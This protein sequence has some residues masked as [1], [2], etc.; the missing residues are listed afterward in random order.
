VIHVTGDFGVTPLSDN[1]IIIRQSGYQSK[2][3][4][5]QFASTVFI[6]D[7]LAVFFNSEFSIR[8]KGAMPKVG[9]C[10]QAV[11]GVLHSG[12]NSLRTMMRNGAY[13]LGLSY[14]EP[15]T[16][17]SSSRRRSKLLSLLESSSLV[18]TDF[19]KRGKYR[20]GATTEEERYRTTMEFFNSIIN[21]DYTLCVRGGGNFS[22]RIYETMALGR[23]PLFV[24]TDSIL[25]FDD[26]ID[27]KQHLVWVE[28]ADLKRVGEILA[29]FHQSIH[30]DDFKQLQ[31]NNRNMWLKYLSGEGFHKQLIECV[32]KKYAHRLS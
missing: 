19:I 3:L 17:Y 29:D 13:H 14:Y 8:E 12:Y 26:Q 22:V 23:I 18:E 20:A 2:R 6:T 24:N 5:K 16:V 27:W 7:P 4:K 21:T 1:D 15:Q 31:I 11:D 10:G 9:F 28:E 32:I 30:P 25:P